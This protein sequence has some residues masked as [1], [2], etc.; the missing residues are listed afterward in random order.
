[1]EV[2]SLTADHRALKR[3]VAFFESD[4]KEHEKN[5]Q[6]VEDMTAELTASKKKAEEQV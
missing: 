4:A 3:E 5:Q 6:R 2:A 1:M